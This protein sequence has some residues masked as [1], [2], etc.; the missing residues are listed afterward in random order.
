[1]S[2]I[3]DA[4]RK[5]EHD[6]QMSAGLSIG[7]L[8]PL[9]LKR[10][11]NVWPILALLVLAVFV[12]FVLAWWVWSPSALTPPALTPPTLT[13]A[14]NTINKPPITVISPPQTISQETFSEPKVLPEKIPHEPETIAKAEKP[15]PKFIHRKMIIPHADTRQKPATQTESVAAASAVNNTVSVDPLKNLPPLE[16]S[17]YIHNEQSGNLAIINNQLVHEGEEVLPG[18]MLVKILEN[19]AIFSYRGYVFSR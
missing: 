9:E 4:L 12:T 13:K 11:R 18:L 6:R 15:V 17:G 8:Y 16:I 5:S 3:L 19:S 7:L 1:M 2:Y 14:S 10:K